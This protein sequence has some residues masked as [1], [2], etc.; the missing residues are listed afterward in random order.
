MLSIAEALTQILSRFAPGHAESV[1]IGQADG[2]VLAASLNADLALP[3][4]SNSAMDGYAVR[5]EPELAVGA[6][7]VVCGEVA[8]GAVDPAPLNP[9]AAV[10]IFTGAPLPEG[11]DT[12]IMQENVRVV[13]DAIE[14]QQAPRRRGEHVRARA[15]DVAP[16]ATYLEVG[17]CLGPGDIALLAAQ[18]RAS[19][20]VFRR[21]RVAIVSTG[22]ELVDVGQAR[23][24]GSIVNS[25]AYALAA[26]VREAGGVPEVLPSA[27]DDLHL[28][29]RALQAALRCDV[30][31]CSGGVSVG[32]YDLVGRAF[33]DLDIR[34][35]VCKVA[36]KPGK[37]L[38][39]GLHGSTP[40]LGLP[41]NPVSALVTFEVFVRPALRRMGGHRQLYR[42]R[43]TAVLGH[44]HRR[45][46]GRTEF[47]R[48]KL[49]LTRADAL[50]TLQLHTHQGS[51]ALSS[52]AQ[53]DA[54][55]ILPSSIEQLRAGDE[56][57]ALLLNCDSLCS[58]SEPPFAGS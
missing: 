31:L 35:E 51:G 20:P 22:D 42:P 27:P 30:V 23:R 43:I 37:P 29:R 24:R 2:R 14:L 6:R 21:P 25:N 49:E 5:Y 16:G 12:V 11:A 58:L 8:A 1:T 9:G 39:F 19:V 34:T 7:L 50:P 13:D 26:Q 57:R 33:D 48:A 41:G 40:V 18:G 10:R 28:I 36:V 32:D 38:R 15:S 47:A 17:S 56:V 44:D 3:P 45:S 53:V 46:T 52:L 55:A 4:F 54:L